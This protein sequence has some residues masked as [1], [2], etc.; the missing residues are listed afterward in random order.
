MGFCHLHVHTEYSFLDGAC[1]VD[2]V[3]RAAGA[4]ASSK[5]GVAAWSF[6]PAPTGRWSTPDRNKI[7]GE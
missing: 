1:K 7:A 3:M 2:D 4:S 6:N 5:P